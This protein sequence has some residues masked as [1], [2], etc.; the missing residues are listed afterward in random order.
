MPY[1]RWTNSEIAIV[2]Y[3]AFRNAD[4]EEC[5]K[6]LN[7]KIARHFEKSRTTLSIRNKLD[8]IRKIES[9]WNEAEGWNIAAVDE[10][11]VA[12]DIENLQALVGV[13]HEELDQISKV[14]SYRSK[15]NAMF[16]PLLRTGKPPRFPSRCSRPNY[17]Q[18]PVIWSEGREP[19]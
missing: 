3:F 1:R 18:W 5:R 2:V 16:W 13:E 10:W 14:S 12:L 19:G 11:L 9:L 17:Y 15:H 8:D 7:L 6:I 4:H